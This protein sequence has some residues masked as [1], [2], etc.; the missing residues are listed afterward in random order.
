MKMLVDGGIVTAFVRCCRSIEEARVSLPDLTEKDYQDIRD[1]K[2]A[3]TGD[4]TN[5]IELVII[6]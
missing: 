1:G 4:T 5:G 6:P 2:A 3:F